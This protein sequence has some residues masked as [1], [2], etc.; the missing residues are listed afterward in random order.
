[1]ISLACPMLIVG[2]YLFLTTSRGT[3]LYDNFA[4]RDI[5]SGIAAM[6]MLFLVMAGLLILGVVTSVCAIRRR[7]QPAWL[8]RVSLAAHLLA[9]L[10]T[11]SKFP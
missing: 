4:S 7:E 9:I 10:A 5:G 2:L 1:M 6:V 8:S 11:V 3:R